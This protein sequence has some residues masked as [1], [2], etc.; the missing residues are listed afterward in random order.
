MSWVTRFHKLKQPD[1]QPPDELD[2]VFISG[3]K[4]ISDIIIKELSIKYPWADISNVS[5]SRLK[6]TYTNDYKKILGYMKHNRCD[7]KIYKH[8]NIDLLLIQIVNEF[9]YRDQSSSISNL[10]AIFDKC[11]SLISGFEIDTAKTIFVLDYRQKY[12]ESHYNYV[13]EL[14]LYSSAALALLN[15]K[16]LFP[17][18]EFIVISDDWNDQQKQIAHSNDSSK[19]YITSLIHLQKK[20]EEIRPHIKISNVFDIKYAIKLIIDAHIISDT[21]ELELF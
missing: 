8:C 2:P 15:K 12:F 9:K 17:F 3:S 18:I 5:F 7:S 16:Y 13:D 14:L 11:S 21:I 4:F 20:L 19:Q 10:N 1:N 6:T